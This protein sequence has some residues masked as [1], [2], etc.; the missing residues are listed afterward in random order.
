MCID[1]LHDHEGKLVEF[2]E[3]HDHHTHAIHF[4]MVLADASPSLERKFVK[5]LHSLVEHVSKHVVLH[6]ITDDPPDGNE[7][8]PMSALA[9]VDLHVYHGHDL[10][11]KALEKGGQLVRRLVPGIEAAVRQHLQAKEQGGTGGVLPDVGDVQVQ[12]MTVTQ[13][14]LALMPF[15]HL[16]FPDVDRAVV[17]DA[18][19]VFQTDAAYLWQIFYAFKAEEIVG[20]VF[21][22]QPTF[23]RVF[24]QYR[25]LHPQTRLGSPPSA[26]GLRTG[27]FPGFNT[28]LVMLHLG[29]MRASD[30]YSEAVYT[31]LVDHLT[32]KYILK[33]R[34]T[35]ATLFTMMAVEHPFLFHV[36]DCK[37]NRQTCQA[38]RGSEHGKV[39][40]Q[41]HRCTSDVAVYHE[42]C[43]TA[44]TQDF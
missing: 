12:G 43:N 38:M 15:Y 33:D 21:E 36:L 26:G 39:F 17:V 5:C 42:S 9:G 22:Q 7:H 23:R 44:V 6:L 10:L 41:Y 19:I 16:L 29:R 24:Q 14:Y 40:E 30:M 2:Y 18:D 11:H 1:K 20:A 3:P 34:L 27:N 4:I 25:K 32:R 13:Q 35:P 31:D 37:W 28:G 8:L